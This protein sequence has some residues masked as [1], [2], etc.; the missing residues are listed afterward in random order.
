MKLGPD[1]QRPDPPFEAPDT[2]QHGTDTA[3]ARVPGDTW[4]KVFGD[5]RLNAMVTEVLQK[6]LDRKQ[7]AAKILE[8]EAQFN[9]TRADRFP[10][11]N[12]QAEARRRRQVA[13]RSIPG[14]SSNRE[15]PSSGPSGGKRKPAHADAN[16]Y[17]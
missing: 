2:Y 7:A 8:L 15:T 14:L 5:P 6:N 11:L 12:L 4:W 13:T 9:Q 10:E 16:D 17:R 1:Y 3:S